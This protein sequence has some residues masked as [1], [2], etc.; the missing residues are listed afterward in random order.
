MWLDYSIPVEVRISMEEYLR[1]VLNDFPEEIT[2]TPETSA[3]SNLFNVRD[4]KERELL[5]NTQSQA[6][7]HAVT[8]LLFTGIRCSKDAQTAIDFL[9]TRVR[10][11]VEDDRK[12]LRRFIG[13]LK[14]KIKLP[15]ILRSDGV[16]LLKWWVDASYAAHDNM[17]GQW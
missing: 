17:R 10:K 6:F 16:N 8:Q 15:L 3:A 2:E 4:N 13:Y 9:T 7:H 5:N 12:K 1:E 14:R 11:P